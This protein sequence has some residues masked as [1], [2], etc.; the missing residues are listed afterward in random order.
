MNNFLTVYDTYNEST[1]TYSHGRSAGLFAMLNWV[2][3]QICL[4]E[5]DGKEVESIKLY[6][7]EYTNHIDIFGEFFSIID[8][9]QLQ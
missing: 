8:F 3:R 1:K 6:L 9:K 2:L 7:D 5:M 4:L